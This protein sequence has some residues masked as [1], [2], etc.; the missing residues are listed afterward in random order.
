MGRN[1]IYGHRPRHTKKAPNAKTR[2]RTTWTIGAVH[3]LE[4]SLSEASSNPTLYAPVPSST[5]NTRQVDA[6]DAA[7]DVNGAPLATGLD[8]LRVV[9]ITLAMVE[10]SRT[11]QRVALG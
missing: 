3:K 1:H 7:V 11:G 4:S 8:G 2:P 10:S 5:K 9:E 6:F